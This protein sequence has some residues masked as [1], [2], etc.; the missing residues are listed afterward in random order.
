MR[1]GRDGCGGSMLT[2]QSIMGLHG[3]QWTRIFESYG[4]TCSAGAEVKHTA[5]LS[6]DSYYVHTHIKTVLGMAHHD[7]VN[8][9]Q[10]CCAMPSMIATAMSQQY[11]MARHGMAQ[12]HA[13]DNKC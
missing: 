13:N 11:N 4:N 7:C 8:N 10:L 3:G 2:L 9:R 6:T 12:L 1:V 5:V